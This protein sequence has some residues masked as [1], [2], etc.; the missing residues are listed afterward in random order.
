MSAMAR[1]RITRRAFAAG[2]ASAL[3]LPARAQSFPDAKKQITFVIPLAAGG[4]ADSTTRVL[5]QKISEM[6][7]QQV[8]VENMGGASGMLALQR[9]SRAPADG[10]TLLVGPGSFVTLGPLMTAGTKIDPVTAFDPITM[11]SRYPSALVVASKLPVTTLAEFIAYAKANPGKMNF[12]SPGAGTM[13]HIG[14]EILKR[15]FGFEAAHVPY[16]GGAPSLGAVV[17]GDVEYTLF[18]PSNVRVQ[19]DGGKLRVLAMADTQR[20]AV[21]P[22]IPTFAELGH[23]GLVFTS[24]TGAMAPR[25]LPPDVLKRLIDLFTE[26]LKS[27]DVIARFNALQI[28]PHTSSPQEMRRVQVEEITTRTPLIKELGLIQE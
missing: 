12:S 27:P 7:G 11:I 16:R 15:R 24:W 8:I 25:G 23:Q 6:I 22:D 3:A 19:R 5:A 4:P 10:Y 28:E 20:N 17:S 26:A 9:V 14:C 18:E 13:P 2:A 1:S 21:L